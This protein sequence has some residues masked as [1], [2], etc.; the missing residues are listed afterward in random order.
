[1]FDI[2]VYS[3]GFKE[4]TEYSKLNG[5]FVGNILRKANRTR[6]EDLLF[7]RFTPFRH[8]STDEE[9]NLNQIVSETCSHYY[10]TKG[11]ITTAAKKAVDF[12]NE[13]L[14]AINSK[15]RFSNNLLGS[16]HFLVLNKDSLYALQAGGSTT[17]LFSQHK[18]EKFEEK[19]YGIEG[20]GIA[21]SIN[22]KFYHSKMGT[23]D[24]LI[25]SSKYPK[26]WT[27][28]KIFDE[29]NLS[30]SHLRRT[31]IGASEGDFE[32]VI[33]Q[34]RDGIGNVHHLKLDSSN[35]LPQEDRIEGTQILEIQQEE[36]ASLELMQTTGTEQEFSEGSKDDDSGT[37]ERDSSMIFDIPP[38]TENNIPEEIVPTQIEKY[39]PQIEEKISPEDGAHRKDNSPQYQEFIFDTPMSVEELGKERFENNI[40]VQENLFPAEQ[41]EN[42]GLTLSGETIEIPQEPEIEVI[43]KPKI[44]KDNNTFAKFLIKSRSFFYKLNEDVEKS[45]KKVN[46]LFIKGIKSTSVDALEN[47]NQLSTTSMLMIAILVAVFVSAIGITVYFQSGI[48]SQQRD[49]IANANILVADALEEP[50]GNNKLLLYEEAY[51]LVTEAEEFGKSQEIEDFKIFIQKEM[52]SLKGVNRL[53]I[54]YTILGGLDRR[55]NIKRMEIDV[56]GDL[57]ALDSDTGRVVRLIATRSDYAVDTNFL[58]GPGKYGD[59]IVDPIIDI[60]SINFSNKVNASLMGI[61]G[62]GNLILCS[63]TADPVAI[64]LKQSEINWGEIKALTFNGYYLYILD[65]GEISRDI[66]RY[67][68]N[69]YQFDLIPESIFSTNIPDYLIGAIDIA[70]NQEELF[71]ID[72]HGELTRCNLVGRNCENNV[73]FGV[74]LDGKS[75]ETISTISGTQLVQIYLTDPPD[76]SIYF[77]DSASSS[78]YHF[79]LALNL[80]QIISPNHNS[81]PNLPNDAQLTSFAVDPNGTIH[82]AYANLI[83]YGFL[84]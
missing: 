4:K 46:S 54:Q 27:K 42:L 75:R 36:L 80:Q 63:S 58:C 2:Y 8:L 77:L 55:I 1:M 81:V 33:I 19:S 59:V 47:E 9:I 6:I 23:N 45:K 10:R 21:R 41:E 70:A 11:P 62:R 28:E 76:P 78:I 68:A 57:Y 31:L 82:F 48:G 13:K 50:D 34:L 64:K 24:R 65:S 38:F 74:I 44:K 29:K 32:A 52:D 61:D 5:L 25:L 43:R 56:S 15:N 12:F 49:L 83:Y 69:D 79:S 30:I 60:E 26:T 14:V 72:Q 22:T 3:F 7:F 84:P 66:Y 16:I 53:N 39:A 18:L 20:I 51:R 71:L 17:F 37:I 67:Q 73:G 40:P 35:E